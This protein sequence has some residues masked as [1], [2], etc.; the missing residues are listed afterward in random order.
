MMTS[1]EG[2]FYRQKPSHHTFAIRLALLSFPHTSL[3]FSL[4]FPFQYRKKEEEKN[5]RRSPFS[6]SFFSCSISWREIST[7]WSAKDWIT[8]LRREARGNRAI[9]SLLHHL[10]RI[11][12]FWPCKVNFVR[13]IHSTRTGIF[14]FPLFYF[15]NYPVL[16]DHGRGRGDAHMY[17]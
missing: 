14:I 1:L 13:S 11:S 7:N 12:H 3:P 4:L 8:K 2:Y 6:F 16:K 17:M 5:R 9:A 10:V 15:I